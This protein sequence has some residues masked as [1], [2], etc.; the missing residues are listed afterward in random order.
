[1]IENNR[2]L[3][4]SKEG[5]INGVLPFSDSWSIYGGARRD[6][7]LNR[8]ISARGG[9]IYKNE[10]FN[11]MLDALRTYTTDR[12]VQPSTA[13]TVTVGFKNLGEIGGN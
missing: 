13:V 11:L 4:N 3:T 10:C 7:D 12:D 2:Y 5:V 8:M 1:A 6:F 9:A